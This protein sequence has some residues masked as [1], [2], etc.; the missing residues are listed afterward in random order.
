MAVMV[1][2]F[3]NVQ[4]KLKTYSLTLYYCSFEIIL[5]VVCIKYDH[6]V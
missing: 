3:S 4:W 1:N 6:E 2:T 5:L